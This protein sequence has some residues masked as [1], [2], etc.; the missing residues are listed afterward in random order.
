ML[1]LYPAA[2]VTLLALL[3][4]LA[5]HLLV[6]QRAARVE[7]PTLRFIQ[8]V[9]L[10]S[11]QRRALDDVWLLLIRMAVLLAAVAALAG[12]FLL[13]PARRRAWDERIVRATI[14]APETDTHR[15][16]GVFAA[17]SIR[18]SVVQASAW[19]DRQPPGRREIV[20]RGPL[21]IGSISGADL[22]HVP[23]SI[24]VRFERT[25][26]V[27]AS[28][29]LPAPLA[30][31]ANPSGDAM[32][33]HRE[34]VLDRERTSVAQTSTS[35]APKFPIDVIAQDDERAA[36]TAVVRQVLTDG[37]PVAPDGRT[38]R[39]VLDRATEIST[40]SVEPVIASI[41]TPWIAEA[42]ARTWR[43]LPEESARRTNL[44]FEESASTF[45]VTAHAH[46]TDPIVPVLLHAMSSAMAPSPDRS[47]DDV[48][49]IS[50]E[51][52]KTWT[53]APGAAAPPTPETLTHDD[54]MWF[55]I[56]ALALL[57]I[58]AWARR[59]RRSPAQTI[60]QAQER[61]RVA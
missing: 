56:A 57:A 60:A 48:V 55:W 20:V 29:T 28:R 18:E 9:R 21:A 13:T 34:I 24:G 54:R 27:P 7:F 53:R 26:A 41:A 33:V 23:S 17:Q 15:T 3:A 30:L 16:D 39:L 47:Q 38:A 46:A 31:T 36:I 8:P 25:G 50:D 58:E 5:I 35:R 19:L 52:L 14:E 42:A 6:H 32:T 37:V 12:P 49:P 11:I 4:P 61:A 51:Q 40:A 43:A 10:A 2:G 22:D 1:W 44:R 59:R 45:V